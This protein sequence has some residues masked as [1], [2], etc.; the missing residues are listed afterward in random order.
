[1]R[2]A[3]GKCVRYALP[4]TLVPVPVVGMPV[5]GRPV[6]ASEA[7]SIGLANR[8][9]PKGQAVTAA[10][11]LAAQIADLYAAAMNGTPRRSLPS[12]PHQRLRVVVAAHSCA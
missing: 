3:R 12:H 10:Q 6:S 4:L 9:V 8:V 2:R 5:T 11:E 7:L 1:M